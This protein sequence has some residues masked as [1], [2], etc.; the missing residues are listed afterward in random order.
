MLSC[1]SNIRHDEGVDISAGFCAEAAGYFLFD[2]SK[3]DIPLSLIVVKGHG[4][5]IGKK[6]D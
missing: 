3:P 5:V 1:G 2:F 4:E 6:A